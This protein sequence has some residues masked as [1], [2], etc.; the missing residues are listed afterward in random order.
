MEES[1][2]RYPQTPGS[3]S[4]ST[5]TPS[6]GLL[7]LLADQSVTFDLAAVGNTLEDLVQFSDAFNQAVRENVPITLHNIA[8]PAPGIKL[9]LQTDTVVVSA[10]IKSSG[11]L[12]ATIQPSP[13]GPFHLSVPPADVDPLDWIIQQVAEAWEQGVDSI[14]LKGLQTLRPEVTSNAMKALQSQGKPKA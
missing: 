4:N 5:I 12:S 14:D 7:P 8:H 10:P 13:S 6:E 3:Y 11:A 9:T 1:K 2:T